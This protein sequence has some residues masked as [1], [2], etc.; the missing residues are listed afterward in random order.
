MRKDLG[1]SLKRSLD[2]LVIL[3]AQERQG[4]EIGVTEVQRLLETAFRTAKRYISALE[5]AGFVKVEA[6]PTK[7]VVRLTD[8]GRCIARCLVS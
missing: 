4:K 1:Y 2:L 5:E 7:N 3:L 6:T 8:R